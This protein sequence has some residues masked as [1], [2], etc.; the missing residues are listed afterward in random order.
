MILMGHAA[1]TCVVV[2][3]TTVVGLPTESI[4]IG[5]TLIGYQD[6]QPP[7]TPGDEDRSKPEDDLPAAPL[8][9][10]LDNALFE[11][12]DADLMRELDEADAEREE[13]DDLSD[14]LLNELDSGDV[15]SDDEGD[16]LVQVGRQMREV[17]ERLQQQAGGE[18]TQTMQQKIVERLDRLMQQL[19]Q[20][21]QSSSSSSSSQSNSQQ[22]RRREVRQPQNRQGDAQGQQQQRQDSAS[23]QSTDRAGQRDAARPDPD[24]MKEMVKAI[25]GHLPESTR[26]QLLQSA[27]DEYLPKYQFLIEQYYRRLI[28]R[29][30]RTP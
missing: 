11:D 24:E 2:A 18:A 23:Q 28:D 20:Q 13:V 5:S 14:D 16:P 4:Y 30:E 9:E 26:Q 22:S 1:L 21:Q 8:D 12:L 25:W 6:E 27:P 19:R 29:R 17:A 15:E 7:G 10:D 3:A